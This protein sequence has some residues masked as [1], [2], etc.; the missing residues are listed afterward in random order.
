[1]LFRKPAPDSEYK[2]FLSGKQPA[3]KL[4]LITMSAVSG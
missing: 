3:G 1:M 4:L 2:N